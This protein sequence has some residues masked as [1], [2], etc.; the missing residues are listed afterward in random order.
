[1]TAA[2]GS[3]L[4]FSAPQRAQSWRHQCV[5]LNPRLL[6]PSSHFKILAF[7]PFLQPLRHDDDGQAGAPEG[8]RTSGRRGSEDAGDG[9]G[10]RGGKRRSHPLRGQRG[11]ARGHHHQH[12]PPREWYA[13]GSGGRRSQG[14]AGYCKQ[15]QQVLTT[16]VTVNITIPSSPPAL[17]G[18]APAEARLS[19][20]SLP[21]GTWLC[22]KQSTFINH[23]PTGVFD[24]WLCKLNCWCWEAWEE[25]VG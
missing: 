12:C 7:F 9:D 21:P 11:R 20:S 4:S 19:V 16:I 2:M 22:F 5:V 3:S 10:D 23:P 18:G 17:S 14:S 25:T 15:Q 13:G 8:R 1:M 6:L 24:F